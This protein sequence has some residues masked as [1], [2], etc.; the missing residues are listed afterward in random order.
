MAKFHGKHYYLGAWSYVLL[1]ILY[2]IPVIGF[3]F[4][5]VHSFSDQDENRRHY[6]R[7]YFARLLLAIII[8]LIAVG[9]FYLAAGQEAFVAK[10]NEIVSQNPLNN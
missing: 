8:C 4:L 10:I 2:I 3:I 5:L 6:A 9:V 1:D 7:S